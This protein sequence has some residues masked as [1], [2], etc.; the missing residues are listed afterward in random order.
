LEKAIEQ[1]LA[2]FSPIVCFIQSS[3]LSQFGR[4][5][6]CIYAQI[7]MLS[8]FMQLWCAAFVLIKY[9][10]DIVLCYLYYLL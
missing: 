5:E 10:C 8:V 1:N 6:F 9:L 7:L 4:Y 3:F 2:P